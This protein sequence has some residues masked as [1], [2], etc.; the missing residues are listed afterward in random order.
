[1]R[2]SNPEK[3]LQVLRHAGRTGFLFSGSR[4]TD[5]YFVAA[6]QPVDPGVRMLLGEV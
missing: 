1:M 5:D 2:R 4:L 3:A 6:G